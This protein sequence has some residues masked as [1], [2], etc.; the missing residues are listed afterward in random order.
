[1]IEKYKLK[2]GDTRWL[3][4][5]YLGRDPLTG[6][7]KR[8]TRRGFRTRKAAMIAET[9]LM[10]TVQ[11]T[12]E[13]ANMTL[14]ELMDI[15]LEQYK[16]RVKDTTY[17]RMR[18]QLNPIRRDLGTA[19]IKKLTPKALQ[20]H[21]S[22]Y[23]YSNGL[24]F[25]QLMIYA[26]KRGFLANNPLRTVDLPPKPNKVHMTQALDRE[27]IKRLFANLEQLNFSAPHLKVEFTT[28]VRT[29]LYT[30]L[31]V[32][33]LLGLRWC[34]VKPDGIHVNH[35]LSLT[36]HLTT[37]KTESSL[38]RVVIDDTTRKML[39]NWHDVQS[40]IFPDVTET[41]PVF[42]GIK[43]GFNNHQWVADTLRRCGDGLP[44]LYCH[45]L[46]HTHASL[47]FAA[48]YDVKTI[49]H[50]LGHSS[51]KTTL[52]VYT[53]ILPKYDNTNLDRFL[54]FMNKP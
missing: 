54:N 27:Q 31:R 7:E 24:V 49:Q 17:I 41:T 14:N 46:R 13:T 53:H 29:L 43:G 9:K 10:Q 1:M 28:I 26:V 30:G 25:N 32:G 36:R 44:P 37:P 5:V 40:S 19:K 38:R 12:V 2:S 52:D 11:P 18:R 21:V 33:E 16:K 3:C 45:M 39:E 34:D 23:T 6:K 42:T 22:K 50:R 8:T 51:I 47:L 20:P 35:T 4:K 15:F 48:G